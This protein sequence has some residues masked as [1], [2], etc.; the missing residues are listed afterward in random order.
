MSV[1]HRFLP[2]AGEVRAERDR[3]GVALMECKRR[4]VIENLTV[5]IPEVVDPLV[6]DILRVLLALVAHEL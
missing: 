6:A 4:L 3:T 5:A 2:T 1:P